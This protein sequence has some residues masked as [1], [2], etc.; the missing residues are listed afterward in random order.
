MPKEIGSYQSNI[1]LQD[2]NN[3]FFDDD[4]AW[5]ISGRSALDFI[6]NDIKSKR[7]IKKAALPSWCC[8]SM[9]SPFVR[10]GIDVVFYDVTIKDGKLIKK[11]DI[12]ADVLLN[13]DYF[14]FEHNEISSPGIVISDI[15]H[16]VF[17]EKDV[18]SDYTFC[19]LRKWAGFVTAGFAWAKNGFSIIAEKGINKEYVDIRKKAMNEK[20]DYLANISSS[21]DYYSTFVKTEE[22]LD[23]LFGYLGTSEDINDA[24]YLNVDFLVNRRK[25]NARV[26]LDEFKDLAIFKEVKD[27]DCPL[28][29]PIIVP[30]GE[31]EELRKYLVSKNI[32]CPTH[33]QLTD[34]HN[35]S[36]DARYIYENELSLICDQRYSTEDMKFLVNEIKGF[37]KGK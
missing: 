30:N 19:S 15:T 24:K 27:N 14:G 17:T 11:I 29:F 16:S 32:Y 10:N 33:W 13:I 36:E 5:F 3:G 6:I 7:E 9:I 12:D 37:Y 28:Y 26:L 23:S 31:K 35:I 25:E 8:D 34:L 20:E 2:T 18:R 22:Q 21:K 1:V 4:L